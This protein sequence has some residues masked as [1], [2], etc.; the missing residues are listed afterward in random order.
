MGRQEPV[1]RLTNVELLL[2]SRLPHTG[3]P[4]DL[5]P[6]KLRKDATVTAAFSTVVILDPF[7]KWLFALAAQIGR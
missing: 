7:R 3:V 6:A 1:K 5:P 4:Y 2:P